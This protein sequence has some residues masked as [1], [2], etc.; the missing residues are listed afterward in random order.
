[1]LAEQ[2]LPLELLQRG[3]WA[4]VADIDGEPT[5][6]HRLRNWASASAVHLRVLQPGSPCFIAHCRLANSVFRGDFATRILV[7]PL[8]VHEPAA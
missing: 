8:G 4:E 3:E 6:V 5:W 2:L 1:M 7:R